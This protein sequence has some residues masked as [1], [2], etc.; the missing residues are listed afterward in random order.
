[1]GAKGWRKEGGGKGGG[2][3]QNSPVK[4]SDLSWNKLRQTS[5]LSLE[6]GQNAMQ[7]SFH[8]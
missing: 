4:S 5:N 6:F 3:V 2:G 1:M 8:V 7:N